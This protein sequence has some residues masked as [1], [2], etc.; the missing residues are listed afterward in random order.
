MEEGDDRTWI[1][2]DKENR[3]YR[4]TF[5]SKVS[6]ILWERLLGRIATEHEAAIEDERYSRKPRS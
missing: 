2:F 6:E 4:F 1:W 3:L 5:F